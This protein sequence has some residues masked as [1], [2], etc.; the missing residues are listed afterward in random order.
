VLTTSNGFGSARAAA[1]APGVEAGRVAEDDQQQDRQHDHHGQG[2]AVAPQLAELLD[3][4]CP[5][6]GLRRWG[7]YLNAR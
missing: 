6:R 3:D 5:H 1:A 2:A 7:G 4:H